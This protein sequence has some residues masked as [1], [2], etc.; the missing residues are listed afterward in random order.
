[1]RSIATEPETVQAPK[2]RPAV[3]VNQSITPEYIVCLED[4]RKFKS[5]KRYLRS[6]YNMSPE[7]YRAKWALP[8]DYPLIAPN[9]AK[10]R[11]DIAR[12]MGLGRG[13]R[14]AASRAVAPRAGR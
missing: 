11:S 4:G 2:Q 1:M 14:P 5:L 8:A 10:A 3:P 6:N 9:Y 13:G 7:D 12:R